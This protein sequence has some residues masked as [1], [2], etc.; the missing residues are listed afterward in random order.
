MALS[1]WLN[2]S[3]HGLHLRQLYKVAKE[4]LINSCALKAAADQKNLSKVAQVLREPMSGSFIVCS[5]ARW[6][7]MS[8]IEEPGQVGG[9]I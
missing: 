3:L 1:N 4:C 8:S 6:Q 5:D 9:N 7:E 2:A